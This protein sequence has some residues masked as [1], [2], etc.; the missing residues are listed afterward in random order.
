MSF[1]SQFFDSFLCSCVFKKKPALTAIFFIFRSY[2][3]PLSIFSIHK[4]TRDNQLLLKKK[5]FL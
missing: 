4:I 5:H 3:V 1:C 2:L